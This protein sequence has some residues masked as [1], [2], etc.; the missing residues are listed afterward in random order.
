MLT[1]KDA[2]GLKRAF[3]SNQSGMKEVCLSRYQY[4]LRLFLILLYE[5]VVRMLF[6]LVI[7]PSFVLLIPVNDLSTRFPSLKLKNDIRWLVLNFPDKAIDEPSALEVIFGS[8]LPAD[9]H[10]QLK[11]CQSS[12]IYSRFWTDE[13]SFF[14]TG[15]LS[16]P[17]KL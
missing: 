16:T 10:S 7:L 4:L 3:C 6:L 13:G 9:V 17:P 5:I 2:A 11:V 15:P 14:Y 12:F 8:A 1:Y